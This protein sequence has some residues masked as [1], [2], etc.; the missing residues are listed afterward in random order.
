MS[1]HSIKLPPKGSFSACSLAKVQTSSYSSLGGK[2][3]K[4]N[5]EGKIKKVSQDMKL[6]ANQDHVH[7]KVLLIDEENEFRLKEVNQDKLNL[8]KFEDINALEL[9]EMFEYAQIALKK[10]SEV[11]EDISKLFKFWE[12]N[13]STPECLEMVNKLLQENGMKSLGNAPKVQKILKV[14]IN[15][16]AEVKVL[17]ESLADRRKDSVQREFIASL[18]DELEDLKQKLRDY[19]EF[20]FQEHEF[21]KVVLNR[22]KETLQVEQ[23]EEIFEKIESFQ[24]IMKVVPSLDIFVQ[25]VCREL[26]PDIVKDE[27]DNESFAI[28]LKEVFPRVKM[29]KKTVE[30]LTEFKVKVLQSLNLKVCDLDEVAIEKVQAVAFFEKLFEVDSSEDIFDVIEKLFLYYKETK[31]LMERLKIKMKIKQSLNGFLLIDELRRLV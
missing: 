14:V 8:D 24:N 28:A 18:Q 17:R 2:E 6:K 31:S 20:S 22:I 16:L 7:D 30:E 1:S 19:H 10:T 11:Q 15:L 29:L 25:Q 5:E 3:S 9:S 4:F 27:Y 26:A 21:D 12:A 23:E 13:E